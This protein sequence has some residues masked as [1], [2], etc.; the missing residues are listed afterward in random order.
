MDDIK[1]CNIL[2]KVRGMSVNGQSPVDYIDGVLDTIPKQHN[3]TPESASP[4]KQPILGA[5]YGPTDAKPC[6]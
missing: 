1:V 5:D 3:V 4:R 6:F 2:M